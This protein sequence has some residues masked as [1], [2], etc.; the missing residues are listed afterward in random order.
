MILFKKLKG[1]VIEMLLAIFSLISFFPN[2]SYLS[3]GFFILNFLFFKKHI[4]ATWVFFNIAILINIVFLVFLKP[5][6]D[7][8]E[9]QFYNTGYS[10]NWKEIT[11]KKLNY[12][13]KK[14][15]EFKKKHGFLPDKLTDIQNGYMD[16]YDLSYVVESKN[17]NVI[18]AHFYY[19]KT[20]SNKYYL[21]GIGPD[22]K[23]KTADDILPSISTKDTINTGLLKYNIEDKS[24]KHTNKIDSKK[25]NYN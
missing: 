23:P 2:L 20:D 24:K 5:S 1:M 16:F 3:I 7:K 17:K 12:Y 4:R 22:G 18:F 15:I 6:F 21:L 19:E 13:N 8:Q 10:P 25:V 9:K 14:I 11:I